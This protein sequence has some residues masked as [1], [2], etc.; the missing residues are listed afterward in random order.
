MRPNNLDK[1]IMMYKGQWKER[2]IYLLIGAV[3]ALSVV[4]LTG[5]NGTDTSQI[6]RYRMCCT[7]RGTFT[8]IS[9]IDT[10]NGVV[11]W[12]GGSSD[13]KPFDQVK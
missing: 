5:A 10:T 9:V 11:K 8:E 12:Y 4:F 2:A 7:T 13:G 1:E 6:G 3:A